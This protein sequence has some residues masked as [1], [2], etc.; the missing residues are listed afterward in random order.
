MKE[1]ILRFFKEET[2]LSAAFAMAIVSMVSVNP[3]KK[4]IDYVNF[5]TLAILLCLMSAMAGLQKSGVF[6][7]VV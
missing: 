2:M 4:Y 1:K 5:W 6:Q 3:D 7:C